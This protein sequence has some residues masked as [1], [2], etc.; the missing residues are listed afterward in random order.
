MAYVLLFF[1]LGTALLN[2]RYL[3]QGWKL[4]PR[5]PKI[6]PRQY[7]WP[8]E[9]GRFELKT[10]AASGSAAA[11]AAAG[12]SPGGAR[13]KKQKDQLG[14]PPSAAPAAAKPLAAVLSSKRP[15][16]EGRPYFFGLISGY[17]DLGI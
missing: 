6:K 4:S 13:N 14:E 17:L 10:A 12:G 3:Y 7:G 2:L 1:G 5:E 8:S 15:F 9:K 16:S 11:G